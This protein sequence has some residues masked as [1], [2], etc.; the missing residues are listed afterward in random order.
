[1]K[2]ERRVEAPTNTDHHDPLEPHDLS[3]TDPPHHH[4]DDQDDPLR[5]M[6]DGDVL[7]RLEWM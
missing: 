7:Q 2:L 4:L 6:S 5:G 3:T 1:M